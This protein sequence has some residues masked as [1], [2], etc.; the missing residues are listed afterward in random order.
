MVKLSI[1]YFFI[2][3]IFKNIVLR[4]K[5]VFIKLSILNNLQSKLNLQ[6]NYLKS[7][8]FMKIEILMLLESEGSAI[9][10]QS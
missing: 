1:F 7:D 9:I 8:K 2:G 6:I 10:Q 4:I 3:F 5:I